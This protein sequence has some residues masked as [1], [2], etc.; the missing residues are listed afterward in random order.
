M[1]APTS[2]QPPI[3]TLAMLADMIRDLRMVHLPHWP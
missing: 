1:A 2:M 3:K